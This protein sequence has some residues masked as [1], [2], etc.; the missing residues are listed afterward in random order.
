MTKQDRFPAIF[1]FLFS[2]FICIES[3]HLRLGSWRRPA[4]GL[5]PFWSGAAVGVLGLIVLFQSWKP[6]ASDKG[7]AIQISWRGMTLCFLALV[8]YILLL[9]TL[10]FIITTIFFMGFLIRIVER[11]GWMATLLTALVVALASYGLFVLLLH[12]ELPEGVLGI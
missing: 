9:K 1:F 5:F 8:M 2:V 6:K 10:G 7:S 3:L 12:S 4:A 11:K